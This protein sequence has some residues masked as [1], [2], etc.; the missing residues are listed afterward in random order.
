M[1][2]TDINDFVFDMV[3]CKR[4]RFG[5]F[6]CKKSE[7]MVACGQKHEKYASDFMEMD[8]AFQVLCHVLE[9]KHISL[10]TKQFFKNQI[11]QMKQIADA[12]K[13]LDDIMFDINSEMTN[14]TAL[15]VR[16]QTDIKKI[17]TQKLQFNTDGFFLNNNLLSAVLCVVPVVIV[18][19]LLL[20]ELNVLSVSALILLMIVLCSYIHFFQPNSQ[21][22]LLSIAFVFFFV[23][24]IIGFN[25]RN[26][27]S[28]NVDQQQ[29][30]LDFW[31]KQMDLSEEMRTCP[32][33]RKINSKRNRKEMKQ[34]AIESLMTADTQKNN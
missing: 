34:I 25:K 13:H 29:N 11:V 14:T 2:E 27:T 20:L 30:L 26:D 10:R 8:N 6:L 7:G 22:C 32:T 28:K 3:R 21:M 19:Q 18:F 17:E 24:T 9:T 23:F 15:L 5:T 16:Q 4:K 1:T 31:K 33:K 12:T